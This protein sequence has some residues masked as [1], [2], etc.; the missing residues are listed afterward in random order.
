[1]ADGEGSRR[2][3][4]PSRSWRG[5][6]GGN[7]FPKKCFFTDKIPIFWWLNVENPTI[8][9]ICRS[10]CVSPVFQLQRSECWNSATFKTHRFD[11]S[12]QFYTEICLIDIRRKCINIYN[13]TNFHECAIA[14]NQTQVAASPD[15]VQLCNYQS[16]ELFVT[17]NN[18]WKIKLFNT[19]TKQLWIWLLPKCG[20]SS[21]PG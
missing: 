17:G 13:N 11:W 3:D 1:M 6:G 12:I 15:I 20:N 2:G 14:K 7:T 4:N 16:T 9:E 19:P 8:T 10:S 21:I 18:F 5:G